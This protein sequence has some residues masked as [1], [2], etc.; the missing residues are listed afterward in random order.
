MKICIIGSGYVGL[1]T[2]ICFA[3]NDKHDVVFFDTN[4]KKI[5]DLKKNKIDIHEKNLIKKLKLAKK[6][7]KIN[8]SKNLSDGINNSKVIFITVGTPIN[9]KDNIDLSQIKEVTNQIANILKK[10]DSYKVIIY[11]STI[12]P[13]TISNYCLPIIEK[14]A[15]KKNGIHFGIASNPEFLREGSAVYDFE[16]PKKIV[17][18][19]N[20]NK[21]KKIILSIYKNYLSNNKIVEVSIETSEMIKYFSNSLFALLISFGNQ[22]GNFCEKI[23]VDF[24]EVLQAVG[25]DNRFLTKKENKKPDFLNYLIPGIGYGGSCFPKDI[26]TLIQT[27]NKYNSNLSILR[28][29]DKINENQSEIISKKI[30]Q[31]IKDNKEIKKILVLGVTFK[32]NTDDLRNS[33][34]INLINN[35]SSKNLNISIYDPILI[36]KKYNE[37]K[38]FFHKKVKYLYNLNEIKKYNFIIVNNRSPEFRKILK[39]YADKNKVFLF[40]SRRFFDKNKFKNYSGS[41]I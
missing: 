13:G 12:P 9:K 23:N 40:D 39:N 22:L 4:L 26:K 19:T 17:I 27:A 28:E 1:V 15:K 24:M 3:A 18:G 35:L 6:L 29:V 31:I 5:E 8:F 30:Y 37:K 11:K 20:D 38:S 7:K 25:W 33:T 2:G 34:S 32:E 41:G 10:S 14:I 36:K 16:N 21:T